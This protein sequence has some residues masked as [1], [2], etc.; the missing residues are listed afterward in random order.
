[1]SPTHLNLLHNRIR[2]RT[3]LCLNS[4]QQQ[5]LVCLLNKSDNFLA[6]CNQT[7][8]VALRHEGRNPLFSPKQAQFDALWR[9]Y[10]SLDTIVN[11]PSLRTMTGA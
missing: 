3:G 5:D 9:V 8:L 4:T 7:Q 11:V 6:L 10:V 1:M 2:E